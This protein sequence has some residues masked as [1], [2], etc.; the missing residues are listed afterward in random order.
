MW[1][2]YLSFSLDGKKLQQKNILSKDKRLKLISNSKNKLYI[3]EL[4]ENRIQQFIE[5]VNLCK[6]NNIDTTIFFDPSH[7]SYLKKN[8]FYIINQELI[9]IERLLFD[10]SV[11]EIK[12]YNNFNEFNL[13]KNY[14]FVDYIHYDYNA[15]SKLIHDLIKKDNNSISLNFNKKNFTN[16]K[17]NILKEMKKYE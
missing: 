14:Y 2:S 1:P 10:S 16:L 9:I 3:N 7:L 11:E 4:D 8:H 12:Y 15:S 5:F 17:T 6:K 13:N